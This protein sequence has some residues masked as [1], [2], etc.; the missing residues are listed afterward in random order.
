MQGRGCAPK[1]GT[2]M[3][4]TPRATSSFLKGSAAFTASWTCEGFQVGY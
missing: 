4:I 2:V 3:S 1:I